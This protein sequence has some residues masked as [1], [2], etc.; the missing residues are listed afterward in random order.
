MNPLRSLHFHTTSMRAS[1][2]LFVFMWLLYA[3]ICMT[4]TSFASA[5]ATLVA[6]GVLTKSQT[7][8]IISSFYI[9]YTPLQIVGGAVAD[10]YNPERLCLIGL[11]GSAVANAVIFLYPTFTVMLVAWVFNAVAQFALW[12]A[13]FKIL[14]TQTVAR[15]RALILTSC[16]FC[17]PAGLF[18]SFLMA[19]LLPAWQISFALSSL[20]CLA[21]AAGL[22]L[23]CRYLTP[24]I[25]ADEPPVS[26]GGSPEAQKSAPALW[27]ILLLGGLPLLLPATVIRGMFY[28]AVQTLSPTILM[29]SYE[30][31]PTFGNLINLFIIALGMLGTVLAGKFLFPR[32]VK[33]EVTGHAILFALCIPCSLL[34]VFVGKIPLVLTLLALCII[35]MA[36]NAITLLLNF[37]TARFAAIGKSGFIAGTV[38]GMV[39]LG[40]VLEGLCFLPL[41]DGFGWSAVSC[42]WVVL[43][44][45]AALLCALAVPAARRFARTPRK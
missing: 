12:P 39:S 4:K 16:N 40:I 2:L 18:L 11:F 14:T 9:V 30:T 45:T 42:L 5:M 22:L 7:G 23:L 21:L 15:D 37:Y 3:L 34:L 20:V 31:S 32:L 41:A 25:A 17:F 13:V 27:R 8:L 33:N 28:Q 1:R 29:E 19:A 36:V 38:N 35:V 44:L 43:A 10:R 24:R 6:E 26:D